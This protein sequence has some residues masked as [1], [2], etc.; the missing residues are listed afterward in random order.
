M[1]SGRIRAVGQECALLDGRF[2]AGQL[3]IWAT[4]RSVAAR[5]RRDQSRR[6]PRSP[7]IND[8]FP[9]HPRE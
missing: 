5:E 4:L 7:A 1:A 6:V 2:G 8:E 9:E 3:M